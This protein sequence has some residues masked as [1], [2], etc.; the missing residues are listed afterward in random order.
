M[1]SS[2][3]WVDSIN[4]TIISMEFEQTGGGGGGATAAE[5]RQRI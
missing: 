3:E 4:I 5:D 1:W 2:S